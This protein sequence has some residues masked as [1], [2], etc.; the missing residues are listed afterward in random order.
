MKRKLVIVG[1]WK[2]NGSIAD[3]KQ[4]IKDLKP[5][6]SDQVDAGLCVPYTLLSTL[7]EEANGINFKIGAQNMHY[8]ES[9]AFTGEISPD[10]LLEIGVDTVIIGHSERRSYYNE[11]DETVNLKLLKAI[12]KNL[13]P[14]V[15][16]GESLEQREKGMA[17]DIC[18][19]Q[20]EN[21]FKGVLKTDAENV[22]LAYEPIWAIGTGKTASSE[23]AEEMALYIRNVVKDIFDEITADKIRIQYGGS[24]KP[25][26]VEE[27]MAMPNIDGALVG[28]ASLKA[29]DFAKLIDLNI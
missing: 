4:F 21:A 14:I 1:N 25:S 9:G 29:E 11:T 13:H 19:R 6:V 12:E 3:L 24:V 27:L 22:I 15:C 5:S 18:K 23:D 2:M 10:M 7:K 20:V 16:V 17:K 8:N 26:N 28:G